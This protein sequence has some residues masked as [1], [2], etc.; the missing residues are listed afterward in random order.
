MP[1]EIQ[2]KEPTPS[3]SEEEETS[4]ATE[5][6]TRAT[7]AMSEDLESEEEAP[8]AARAGE[9]AAEKRAP[10]KK[11]AASDSEEEAP[12]AARAGEVAAEKRAASDSEEE[13]RDGLR[14]LADEA[15]RRAGEVAESKKRAA[16]DS[17]EEAPARGVKVAAPK[18][19]RVEEDSSS[20]SGDSSDD[21]DEAPTKWTQKVAAAKKKAPRK[22]L[23]TK[24]KVQKK[25]VGQW[26]AEGDAGAIRA[27]AL[28]SRGDPRSL[29]TSSRFKVGG[30]GVVSPLRFAVVHAFRASKR[31]AAM[32][33]ALGALRA[34]LG[35]C[36]VNPT[37]TEVRH[38]LL[39]LLATKAGV[40]DVSSKSGAAVLAVLL[41]APF[42][43]GGASVTEAVACF[44]ANGQARM[45]ETL[46]RARG[47]SLSQAD[48]FETVTQTMMYGTAAM[49]T[50]TLAVLERRLK[51]GTTRHP[52]TGSTLL[53]F[54]AK[55]CEYV[56]EVLPYCDVAA[57]DAKE[58]TALY[59]LERS[60]APAELIARVRGAP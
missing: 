5:E 51:K 41:E 13:A 56:E 8:R 54:A 43:E 46:L 45:L 18:R 15:E 38:E 9:V 34:L 24:P 42:L 23:T 55:R 26:I 29:W 49:V 17:E 6:P 47:D 12:R 32:E 28:N 39:E 48:V 60:G 40:P 4:E 19:P 27:N 52:K 33:A 36:R 59:Y 25:N 37:D 53:H 30:L 1:S 50:S 31:D 58:R 35:P 11:R 21:E 20:D 22:F 14:A 16:S 57:L 7:R 10:S 3:S 2:D 44:A